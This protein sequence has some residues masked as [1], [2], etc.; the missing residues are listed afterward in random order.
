MKQRDLI[1]IRSSGF[2]LWETWSKSWYIQTWEWNR[3]GS[4]AQGSQWKSGKD[5]TEKMEIISG[6]NWNGKGCDRAVWNLH[7]RS[8]RRDSNSIRPW[9]SD[10]K[11]TARYG[12]R[13]F[14]KRNSNLCGCWF[15]RVQEKSGYKNSQK[16]CGIAELAELWSR[17]CRHQCFKSAAGSINE[18]SECEKKRSS[19]TQIK[20]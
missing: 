18:C 2:C 17:A 16:E 1:K 13:R 6:C 8:E 19:R 7:G 10:R 3:K 9:Y 20:E 15:F 11:G 14:F 5:D 12:D 4:K